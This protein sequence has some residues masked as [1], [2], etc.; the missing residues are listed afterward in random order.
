MHRLIKAAIVVTAVL[1]SITFS[2]VDAA[3]QKRKPKRKPIPV[4]TV[5][6]PQSE[7]VV[8][9]RADEFNDNSQLLPDESVYEG[10]TPQ[11]S[12]EQTRS[13]VPT[14]D[15]GN[16]RLRSDY[17]ARQRRL[18]MNLD[19]I[20]RAEQRAEALRRQSFELAE[21]EASLRAK[22]EALTIDGSPERIEREVAF[23]GTL[24]P[25]EVRQARERAIAAER[26]SLNTLLS[27]VTASRRSV[28][29]SLAKA[30]QMVE[31]LRAKLEK[32]IDD[33]IGPEPKP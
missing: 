24:R 32:D 15:G 7:P 18:L 13:A 31:R 29:D 8:V 27:Q 14:S 5:T 9:S 12:T 10:R 22:L 28:D 11:P 19:I 16:D 3:A 6:Y 20:S 33:D 1:G 17:D 23:A 26:A 2:T 25:E 21:K 30:D 4:P